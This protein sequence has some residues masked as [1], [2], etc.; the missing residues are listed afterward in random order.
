[1]ILKLCREMTTQDK[2]I[3]IEYLERETLE[4]FLA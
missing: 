1:M 2:L 3:K 4:N